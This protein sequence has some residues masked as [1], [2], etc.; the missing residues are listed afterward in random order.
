MRT[1]FLLLLLPG[2]APGLSVAQAVPRT[3]T[4]RG[5]TLRVT[6]DPVVYAWD[7]EFT[8]TGRRPIGASLPATVFVHAE[9]RVTPLG[10]EFGIT[11]RI[12][13]AARLP[14]V[15]ATVRERVLHDS[16][17]AGAALDSTLAD[18]AYAFAPIANTQR[19]LR[20]FPGDAEIAAKARFGST[21]AQ[22]VVRLPTGHLD[23]PHDLFDLATGDHQTDIEVGVTE[24]LTVARRLWLNLS[25]RATQQRPGTR[26]RRVAPAG[27]LLA[28]IAALATLQWDPGD[29]LA[30]DF[31]PMCRL[32]K[33]G[34]FAVGVTA[35]YFTKRRDHY[36][37]RS[38]ADSVALATRLG[39]PRPASVLDTGTSERRVRLGAALSFVGRDVE[40]GLAFEQT[41]SG[42]GGWIPSATV[43]RIV[44]R[45]SRLPF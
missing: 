34:S 35:A 4:P 26:A 17:G 29:A 2:L 39:A 11:D 16:L 3:D 38:A 10:L 28:P 32:G 20:Y 30:V 6:V 1:S 14:L 7:N 41:V 33:G 15:R 43:L 22:L 18:T 23:S 13:L 44:M 40:G 36:S 8:P 24:E 31:A 5:G 37:F 9:R 12:A 21:A 27:T 25:V 45:T 42:A 19:R